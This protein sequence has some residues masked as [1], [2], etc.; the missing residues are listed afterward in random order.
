MLIETRLLRAGAHPSAREQSRFQSVRLACEPF[1][2]GLQLEDH[3]FARECQREGVAVRREHRRA[4]QFFIGPAQ[5]PQGNGVAFV[6]MWITGNELSRRSEGR[7]GFELRVL[8]W[9]LASGLRAARLCKK[10]DRQPT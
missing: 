5:L 8:H 9:L 10:C 2:V 7:D 1:E 3:Q 6:G 4:E